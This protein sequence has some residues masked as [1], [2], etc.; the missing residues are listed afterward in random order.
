VAYGLREIEDIRPKI[1]ETENREPPLSG[2]AMELLVKKI[3]EQL[4]AGSL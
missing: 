3:V 1:T 2:E 4:K